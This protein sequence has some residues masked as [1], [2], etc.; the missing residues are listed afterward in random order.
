MTLGSKESNYFNYSFTI[1]KLASLTVIVFVAFLYFDKR[2]FEPFF[3]EEKGGPAGTVLG[4][5]LIFMA[6]LGYDFITT[7]S[8]E[9]KNPKR[10]MPLSIITCILICTV[11]YVLVGISL[12]G[13]AR[14]EQF[15][16][17][18]AM[19]LAFKHVGAEWMSLIIYISAFFGV[20]ACA[21]TQLM[22]IYYFNNV[23]FSEL[24][25]SIVCF[26]SRWF[27]L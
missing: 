8:Q 16:G 6:Y 22:V 19:A 4:A 27:I 25:K 11:L 7:L 3:L 13:V 23:L 1:A 26:R 24:T 15:S 21:F 20:S 5:S 18:T 14:L 2:N 17:D 12:S 9:A 10:D